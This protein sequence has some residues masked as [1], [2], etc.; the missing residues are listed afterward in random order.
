MLK[1][2]NTLTRQIEDFQPIKSPEVG[3][4]ACG[5]TVYDYLHIGNMRRYVGDDILVRVLNYDGYK[6]KYVINITDVGHL[7]SDADTG[8][9][10][11]EKGSKKFKMSV[12]DIAKKFEKTFFKDWEALNLLDPSEVMHA[13]DYIND[14]IQLIEILEEKGFTYKTSDG[15]YFNT[16]KFPNYA[17]LSKQKIEELKAGAR[18]T[19]TKGKKNSSDFALWKF[20]YPNGRSFDSNKDDSV[21]KRQMEWK[22]PWGIGFPGWHIECSAMSMKALG[23]NFDIH[24]GGIDH[25]SVHHTNEIAQS[26]AASGKKFVNYWV[27]HAF[28]S[29]EEEKM[30]KSLGNFYRVG[31]IVAKG[32]DPLSL[33]YLYLQTHYRKEMNFTFKALDGAQTA[34]NRL[35]DDIVRLGQ[36][37]ERSC[38]EF[39]VLFFAA[40]NDDLNMPQALAIVWEMMKSNNSNSKKAASILNYEKI[41]G[42]KLDKAK[43]IRGKKLEI[44]EEIIRMVK[45]RQKLRKEKRFFLADQLR[46]KIKKMG[47]ELEDSKDG[48]IINPT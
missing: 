28:L 36:P 32:Y 47:Y 12:W 3:I 20:S 27:H 41:L 30:S 7:T 40:V 14:Q 2:Y 4:Y 39:D 15:I 1:I 25:I 48:I 44:P 23:I 33:R 45:E 13:T 46:S 24:T 35:R 10:K 31:E 38:E 17:E 37:A 5:P 18:V 29:V 9:D 19:V 11:M 22:S 21:S 43:E 42:L 16:S 34:L 8:Q 6:I 26:E